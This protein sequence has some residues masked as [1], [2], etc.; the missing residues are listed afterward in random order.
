MAATSL[1]G[2][3]A[4]GSPA[5][6]ESLRTLVL[7]P[8]R[9]IAPGEIIRA[10]F[11][12][13]NAGGATATGVRIR[14]SHP[15]GASHI[16]EAD[17]LD[18]RPLTD[19]GHLADATGALVG[20][21]ESNT[22][23]KVSCS[24]RVND[25]IED[26]TELVFQ[27]A[28]VSNQTPLL[29]SNIERITVRS[30][31]VLQNTS[32]LVTLS[33]SEKPR[34]GDTIT[35]RG[36]VLNS[37]SSS[38]H[39]VVVILPTPEHTSYVPRSARVDGRIVVGFEGE[40][41][42]Y[43]SATVVS[44]I[45]APGQSVTL[46]YQVTIDSPLSDSTRIKAVGSV[47]SR[48]CS[49]FDI[50]SAEIFVSSPVDF[51]TEETAL[52]LLCDD[53][54]VP[55]M[56]IPMTLRAVNAGT[57]AAE[58]VAISFAL[59]PGLSFAPGSAQVDGQPVSDES[60]P[61]LTFSVGTLAAGKIVEVG[62]SATV[63]VPVPGSDPALP[64][65]AALRWKGGERDF[66]RRLTVRVASRF[67]R[68]RNFVEADHGVARAGDDV[69]FT[70]HVYNDGTA[71]EQNVRVRVIP[72]VHLDDVRVAESNDE[73][74]AYREPLDLGLVPPH[75]ERLFVVSARIATKV[76]DR[77]NVTLGVV[78]E[79]QTGAIDLG[80]ATVVVR[81]RPQVARD[82]VAWEVTT[83][84][85]LRPHRFAD[86]MIRFTNAGSDVLRDARLALQLPPD[87]VVERAID[88]RRDRDGLVFGDVP[89]ESTHEARIT[90][91][92][93]R[94]TP[95]DRPLTLE[96]WLH[97]RG[98]SPVQFP[99]LDIPTFAQPEFAESAQLLC[100]PAEF[101]NAGEHI[102]Y[103]I[104]LRNDGD[105]PADRLLV[106][107][108]PTNLAVYVPT[109]TTINGMT[110]GDDAGTSQL[111]SQRGLAL[112]DVNP[113][114]E[115]RIRW[116]M[117][118][119]SPL[120]AGTSLETRAV[121]EWGMGQTLM[122]AAPL[123]KVQAQPSLGETTIGTPI[124]IAR[125]FPSEAPPYEPPPLPEAEPQYEA[126]APTMPSGLADFIFGDAQPLPVSGPPI[127]QPEP[128]VIE[129]PATTLPE[130]AAPVLA[131]VSAAT[132]A[133]PPARETERSEQPRFLRGLL[134][135]VD[136]LTS[137]PQPRI[138]AQPPRDS[139]PPAEPPR[140]DAPVAERPRDIVMPPETP[141]DVV[142]SPERL[143]DDLPAE[144]PNVLDAPGQRREA[145]PPLEQPRVAAAPA[146]SRPVV[147]TGPVLF[148]DF[149]A[150]RLVH[151]LSLLERSDAGGLIPHLFA[152]R[153]LF[154]ENAVS[155]SPKL[156]DAFGNTARAMRAPLERFFV[157]LRMP[158]LTV[159]G[160]DL[161][162]RD[163]RTAL[164]GLLDDI[165]TLPPV[166]GIEPLPGV[167]RIEGAIDVN[168]LRS[169]IPELDAAPLGAV[170]PWVINARMLGTA[171]LHDG[172]QND[173]L[174]A[175]RDQVLKV[176]TVLSE[177]PMDEFHRVLTTSVNRS[178]DES[179]SDLLDALRD[180]AHL[181]IE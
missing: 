112:A 49:E 180:A 63:A 62:L 108:V 161:E 111:W 83:N 92:L 174:G 73:P 84:E 81:S 109:S 74:V 15:Q 72:G 176:F 153:T 32:T 171:V 52:T 75:H 55:G 80:T 132:A 168:V 169:L 51:A 76:P 20:D 6:V 102:Y 158:R 93:L 145:A 2:I 133:P 86:V 166:A 47:G 104:R 36:T 26:G 165:V 106:R 117:S 38:A 128:P 98:I 122:L 126:P 129:P 141:R 79:H 88:A 46:E 66:A 94:P 159:T 149:A 147:P 1:T 11:S 99:P 177:L 136:A 146:Q 42:D 155:A 7:E 58:F 150:D 48:E 23:R 3:F 151:T 170:T 57:G 25:T 16:P 5:L 21:L 90:L 157:R 68:A 59:P 140:E 116:E 10:E 12:F 50:A 44:D 107:V 28:L 120:A 13:S 101:V 41:F 95:Y 139:A 121:L 175:Y 138:T 179:L 34:P 87:I 123:L 19:G 96:G 71:P 61:G 43:D 173:V 118:V 178:L 60:I 115:L 134:D 29:A 142:P 18:D 70:A 137:P 124:S 91:R 56:R 24:F 35:I 156:A 160:K 148:I 69:R 4:P 22:Q 45:L 125:I 89:A 39:D 100:A 64:V 135:R 103:E 65:E 152:M 114:V 181:P 82:S 154:P 119:M 9:A 162:D 31:P 172:T 78:L 53:A 85:P 33:A 97:G 77:S 105:G 144:E 54:V 130:T 167:I 14:F 37:G 67:N 143:H 163:A 110:V 17:L 127:T 131:P 164:R 30:R 8:K 40:A 27:A 113:D